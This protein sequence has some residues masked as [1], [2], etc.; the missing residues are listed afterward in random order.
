MKIDYVKYDHIAFITINGPA[1]QNALDIESLADMEEAITNFDE[2]KELRVAIIRGIGDQAFC[3]GFDLQTVD[4]EANREQGEND[5]PRSLMRGLVTNKPIIAAVNGAAL[6]GGLELMLSC[7][8]RIAATE[9]KF[10]FPEV[11]LGLIPGW[12]GTQRAIRQL[13]WC[14]AAALILT[15]NLIDASEAYRIGLINQVVSSAELM[16]TA[17]TWANIIAKAAPLA[18]QAAKEAMQTGSQTSFP[19]GL[20]IEDGLVSY[21]K[22]T[23]DFAEGMRAFKEKQQPRFKG[24]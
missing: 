10:G 7:D 18:V 20:Q 5:F 11:R 4:D 13:S 3:S 24:L 19:E 16:S 8:I 1:C 14:N 21:L 23:S 12:G 9:A 6:G 15:G 22:T 17:E 2:D